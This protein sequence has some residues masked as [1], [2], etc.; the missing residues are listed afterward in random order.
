MFGF[1]S[2]TL[3]ALLGFVVGQCFDGTVR[4]MLAA[5]VLLAAAALLLVAWGGRGHAG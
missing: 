3:G 4:P 1:L 5:Y 2:T